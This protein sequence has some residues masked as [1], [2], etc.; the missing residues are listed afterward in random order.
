MI[1]VEIDLGG[2]ERL[3]ALWRAAPR[4]AREEVGRAMA[5][6]DLLLE[7]E[8]KDAM[9]AAS[10]TLRASVFGREEVSDTG[11]IGVVGSP[12]AYALPV[13]LGTKPHFPPIEPLVDWVQ[14]RLGVHGREARS[15][16]FLVARKIARKGTDAA[17]AFQGAFEREETAVRRIFEAALGRIAERIARG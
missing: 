5:Q 11:A 9:P 12:L 7:R 6:A 14:T 17:H 3:A 8:V 16:A 1:A 15:V 13:E 10:G 4:I 2:F